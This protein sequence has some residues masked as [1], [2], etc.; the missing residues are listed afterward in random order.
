MDDNRTVEFTNTLG[1]A[2][3]ED[4]QELFEES[5]EERKLRIKNQQI[6]KFE[7]GKA[8]WDSL[9]EYFDNW[10]KKNNVKIE[11]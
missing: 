8:F 1:M 9:N 2:Q 10:S 5:E 7:G 11:K 6:V 4:L 3:F